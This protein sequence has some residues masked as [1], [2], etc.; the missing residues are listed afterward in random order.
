MKNSLT[1]RQRF[2]N[3]LI[4]L[5]LAIGLFITAAEGSPFN[6]IVSFGDSLADT[7][8]AHILT[9][10]ILPPYMGY[11]TDRYSNGLVWV[12]YLAQRLDVPIDDYAVAGA[13]TDDRNF[14]QM[15]TDLGGV[16]LPG[17]ADQIE[18]FLADTAEQPVGNRDLFTLVIGANDLFGYASGL[19][20]LPYPGAVFNTFAAVE[21]FL[22]AGARNIVV[23]LLPD[24]TVTPAFADI[25]EEDEANLKGLVNLYNADLADG[26]RE[27]EASHP[28]TIVIVNLSAFLNELVHNPGDYG[29]TNVTIPA[30]FNLAEAD[31]SLFWD[32]VH[33]TTFGHQLLSMSVLDSMLEVMVPGKGIGLDGNVPG[34]AKVK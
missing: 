21:T 3:R 8:T 24:V 15:T 5:L 10:G 14:A 7:G 22:D 20:E 9:D 28:C 6:R 1:Q 13:Y 2:S 32:T 4:S 16:E 34:W 12:E 23:I 25:S 33:P 29:F 27:L 17:L 26:L 11:P 31:T 19:S 18:M 30:L